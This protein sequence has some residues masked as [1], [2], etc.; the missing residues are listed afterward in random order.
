MIRTHRAT[1]FRGLGVAA[2]A[3]T[4]DPS[5]VIG[6]WTK[7][8]GQTFV[9]TK[10]IADPAAAF[11]PGK[12][13]PGTLDAGGK[14]TPTSDVGFDMKRDIIAG[15]AAFGLPL[16]Y[17]L[18]A[19]KHK[20]WPKLNTWQNVAAVVGLYFATLWVYGKAQSV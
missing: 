7:P 10:D 20:K 3:W 16:V 13:T 18:A 8:D 9:V 17:G 15:A 14:F 11:G 2:P 5:L 19:D 1:P 4:H 12:F 6:Q